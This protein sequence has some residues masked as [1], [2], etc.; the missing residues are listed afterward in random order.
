MELYQEIL[1]HVLS[2]SVQV[3]CLQQI[4]FT[5]REKLHIRN[6][7]NLYSSCFFPQRGI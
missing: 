4:H 6:I 7:F 5:R 3:S 1:C 2:E